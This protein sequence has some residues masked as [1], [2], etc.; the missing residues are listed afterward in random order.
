[1]P[2]VPYHITP[3]ASIN[4]LQY[5]NFEMASFLASILLLSLCVDGAHLQLKVLSRVDTVHS[6]LH[7]RI[8][9]D[10]VAKASVQST[11]SNLPLIQVCAG[12]GGDMCLDA[13]KCSATTSMDS[14]RL[15][16]LD[17]GS[18]NLW[19]MASECTN[20]VG[21]KDS[22]YNASKSK[23][24]SYLKQG[25]SLLEGNQPG[26]FKVERAEEA[27]TTTIQYATGDMHGVLSRDTI[28]I[29]G[30]FCIMQDFIS[31][32]GTNSPEVFSGFS[33]IAGLGFQDIDFESTP[34][35]F[36]TMVNQ[37]L[38]SEPLFF[39]ATDSSGQESL[40]LGKPANFESYFEDFSK[41]ISMPVVETSWWST[42]F[43]GLKMIYPDGTET[44]LVN[45][46]TCAEHAKQ[47]GIGCKL[48]FD[49]G[50]SQSTLPSDIYKQFKCLHGTKLR[51]EINQGEFFEQVFSDADSRD[52]CSH[53]GKLDIFGDGPLF[54]MGRPL[55]RQ[56]TIVFQKD[57]ED[58]SKSSILVGNA[59]KPKD[60]KSLLQSIRSKLQPN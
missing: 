55:F 54:L 53:L 27:D 24:H 36:D 7:Q 60:E 11:P 56:Y 52:G 19:M 49:S 23:C 13:F 18:G 35:W 2:V 4:S 31:V 42:E 8:R 9:A 40:I 5:L 16:A 34:Q 47:N 58:N 46:E 25:I 15:V 44:T 28:K 26:F 1:M 59:A 30:G 45:E 43:K 39:F 37:G 12:S 6:G 17:T 3:E 57:L 50:S 14:C 48:T 29:A 21:D 32:E 41:A 51:F 33:G 22:F 20:C 10:G 38:I